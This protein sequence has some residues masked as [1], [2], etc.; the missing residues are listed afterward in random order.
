MSEEGVWWVVGLLRKWSDLEVAGFQV[1]GK[2]LNGSIGFLEVFDT[3]EAAREVGGIEV[4]KI[5]EVE[6]ERREAR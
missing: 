6:S 5:K 1:R 3:E 4:I 2:Q